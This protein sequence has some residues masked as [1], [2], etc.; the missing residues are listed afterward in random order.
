MWFNQEME[1]MNIKKCDKRILIVFEKDNVHKLK[2]K[3]FAD[4][5]NW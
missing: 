2:M 1:K 3:P 5:G 4:A